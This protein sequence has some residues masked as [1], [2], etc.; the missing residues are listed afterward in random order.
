M[1]KFSN[2]NKKE[3]VLKEQ[4]PKINKLVEHLVKENLQVTYNGDVEEAI[5]KKFSIVGSDDLAEK[6]EEIIENHKNSNGQ[7][8]TES[9]KY[10]YGSQLDQKNINKDIKLLEDSIYLN[11]TPFPQD[12]FSNEDYDQI[13]EDTIVLRSLN[14]I[15]TDYMDY[16]NYSNAKKYFESGNNIKMRYNSGSW[17]LNF[18][19]NGQYGTTIDSKEDKYKK[20]ITEN[21]DFVA[22]FLRATS[23]L[24]G[25]QN[26][27]LNK[28]LVSQI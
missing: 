11:V 27:L 19:N 15:P 3:E 6:L 18:E 7:E 20:F 9:L 23:D 4:K 24:V 2:I 5:T 25:T 26:L 22:D 8:L 14:N 17:E 1:K 16:V 28:F 10:K 12:V 13:H 21:R